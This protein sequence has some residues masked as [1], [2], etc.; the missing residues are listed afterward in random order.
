MALRTGKKVPSRRRKGANAAATLI[1]LFIVG[2]AVT[3]LGIYIAMQLNQQPAPEGEGDV[4]PIELPKEE[5][6]KP[7]EPSPVFSKVMSRLQKDREDATSTDAAPNDATS[8]DTTSE[9]S[10]TAAELPG[11]TSGSGATIFERL[12]E[13]ITGSGP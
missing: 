1:V 2:F 9:E 12:G 6:L 13:A 10:E 5:A 3:A 4:P 11:G 8:E 7:M